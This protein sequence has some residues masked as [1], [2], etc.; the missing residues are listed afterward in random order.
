[1]ARSTWTKLERL[2]DTN[3]YLSTPPKGSLCADDIVKRCGVTS[4]T[5]RRKMIDLVKS[6]KVKEA[7]VKRVGDKVIKR[8]IYV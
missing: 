7:F 4:T 5:A 8:Y 6:G 3:K 1:M 2:L